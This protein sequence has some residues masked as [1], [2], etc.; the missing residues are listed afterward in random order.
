MKSIPAPLF[1]ELKNQTSRIDTGWLIVRTDGERFGFTSSDT[2]FVYNGDT[3]SPANGF[4]GSAIVSKADAS[5]D[6]MECQVLESDRI[7]AEDLRAGVWAN[8]DVNVFWINPD[9]P[10][11]GSVPL[12]GGTMGE[13]V[14]KNGQFTVQLRSLFQQL[15]QPFGVQYT[16][17]CQAQL[18]DARCKVKLAAPVWAPNTVYTLGLLADAGVGSVVA[19]TVENDFWYVANY[20]EQAVS[21]DASALR[22]PTAPG[23][24]LSSNDDLGPNDNT[25]TGVGAPPDNLNQF[26]YVGQP[27]DVFGIRL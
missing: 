9:H 18:G 10:E 6:N 17:V 27:V 11:W 21:Y 7:T 26:N 1:A 13:V 12:R 22:T 19:P 25:Q 2:E 8:A 15:Q 24:G 5:V 16:L 20:T 23:Q 4:N 3:Y 14:L